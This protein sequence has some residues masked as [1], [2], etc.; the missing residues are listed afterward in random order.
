MRG[1]IDYF[2]IGFEGPRFDGSIMSELEHA[3]DE[4][5]IALVALMVLYKNKDGE[6][7][8]LD[9]HESGDRR[10]LHIAERFNQDAQLIDDDDLAEVAEILPTDTAAAVIVIEHLWAKPLKRAIMES[11]GQLVAEGRIHPEA[12]RELSEQEV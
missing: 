2:V 3:L 9:A 10:I 8:Q 11:G 5:V 12:E 4:G 1:P 7:Q 6:I